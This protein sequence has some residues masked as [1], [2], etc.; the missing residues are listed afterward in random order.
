MLAP[1]PAAR[2][3]PGVACVHTRTVRVPPESEGILT[4]DARRLPRE[5]PRPFTA[6]GPGRGKVTVPLPVTV[7]SEIGIARRSQPG[8]PGMRR[9]VASPGSLTEWPSDDVGVIM[10]S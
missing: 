4:P 7:Q 10:S 1:P 8:P 2:G 5:P 3:P 9:G 6:A